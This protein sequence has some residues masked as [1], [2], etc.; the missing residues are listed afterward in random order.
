MS[1]D[2]DQSGGDPAGG[3]K[4]GGGQAA[5]ARALLAPGAE[6]PPGLRGPARKRFDVYRNTVI[7]TL[8]EALRQGFPAV[9][10]LVG[11][12][13]FRAMAAEHARARPPRSPVMLFY[14]AEFPDWIADFPPA[15]SVPYLADVA[16][17]DYACREAYHAA[18]APEMTAQEVQTALA[19]AGAELTHA[20][21]RLAPSL[22][23][24]AA[25]HPIVA[26][27]AKALDPAAPAPKA[28]AQI[29]LVARR[30]R[31]VAALAIPPGEAA[32]IAA[33]GRG[34]TIERAAAAGAAADPNFDAG[35]A[36]TRLLSHRLIAELLF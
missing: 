3:G 30:G 9:E 12:A 7:S 6:P 13:F 8:V 27:R 20:R 15:A 34:E 31:A 16:R 22:R 36:I 4:T 17:L 21:L 25:R 24:V 23:L 33:L 5:F 26:I 14:G 1:G 18:D 32:F 11:E 19:G 10:A 35:A 28:G 2:G 29:A